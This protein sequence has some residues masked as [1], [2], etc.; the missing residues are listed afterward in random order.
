MATDLLVT[1][2]TAIKGRDTMFFLGKGQEK[3]VKCRLQMV[4]EQALVQGRPAQHR[5]NGNCQCRNRISPL[6][7][8]CTRFTS[9][10]TSNI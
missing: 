10:I 5:A 7:Y 3:I 1:Q 9:T 4:T 8:P 2:K 6:D